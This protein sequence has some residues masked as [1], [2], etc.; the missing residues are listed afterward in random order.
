MSPTVP[1][2]LFRVCV[3]NISTFI[4]NV[5]RNQGDILMLIKGKQMIHTKYTVWISFIGY[6]LDR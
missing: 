3:A 6:I 2:F 5:H 4:P 1:L